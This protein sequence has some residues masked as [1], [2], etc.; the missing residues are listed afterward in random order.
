[1]KTDDTC[2][3]CIISWSGPSPLFT[4]SHG[5]DSSIAIWAA[6]KLPLVLTTTAAICDGGGHGG[7]HGVG[8]SCMAL[9]R[10]EVTS[11]KP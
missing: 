5:E 3:L 10:K 7:G 9:S 1:M 8:G 4:D 2:F 6:S 11:V